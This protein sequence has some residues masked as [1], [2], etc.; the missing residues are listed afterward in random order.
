MM[1][2][3]AALRSLSVSLALVGAADATRF[4]FKNACAF[5]IDLWDNS[6]FI[7]IPP[8]APA[9]VQ[10]AARPGLMWRHG[11]NPQATRTLDP[12]RCI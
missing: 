1:T 9:V 6:R 5:Q 7:N 3:S 2:K 4:Y 12:L 8:N 11:Y 10:D